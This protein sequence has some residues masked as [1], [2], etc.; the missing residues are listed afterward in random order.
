MTAGETFTHFD[1]I[2][3]IYVSSATRLMTDSE[4]NDLLDH[5]RRS[6]ETHGITGILVY[7]EGNF[8]QY[9]EGEPA[10]LDQLMVNLS[11]DRR[12]SG[13]IVID[14]MP[15]AMRAFPEWSMAFDRKTRTESG[16]SNFLVGG[17]L[18]SDP[19]SLPPH[20]RRLLDIFRENI[21]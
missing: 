15:I 21:R 2:G 11:G 17:F 10:K 18:H 7:W 3:L 9:V 6:N 5:A 16:M 14:R 12:H 20:V 8:I 19:K 1:L 13:I 4:I